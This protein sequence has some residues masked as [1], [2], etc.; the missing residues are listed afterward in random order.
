MRRDIDDALQGWPFDPAEPGEVVAREVKARDG[1]SV[2]QVRIELGIL[3]MESENRPDGVRPHGFA[4]Y[5]DYLRYRAAGRGLKP[6]GKS[7]PWTMSVEHC[8]E[9]DREFVQFYHRRIAWLS[10]QRYEKAV[11]DAEHTL[12]LMDFVRRHG[13]DTDYVASHER[14]RGM[15][16]FQR[17]QATAALALQRRKPEEA[18]DAIR[19]GVERLT[20]HYREW[21]QD[22]EADEIPNESLVE[23][24]HHLVDEIRKNFT[25]SKT[26]REQLDEAV[27]L[28]DYEKAARIRDKLRGQRK[29]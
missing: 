7:P 3:Q 20:K 23:Q 22:H 14:F 4:T 25:V 13:G 5:L 24:L 16:L 8:F 27:A 11:V 9:A 10:L 29:H 12:A 21:E 18:I 2:L 6:G 1:R 28:E 15:V 19:D 26:L 17:T